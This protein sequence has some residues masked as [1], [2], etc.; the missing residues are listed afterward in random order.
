MD[1]RWL[2]APDGEVAAAM[3]RVRKDSRPGWVPSRRLVIVHVN[4]CLMIWYLGIAWVSLGV[5]IDTVQDNRIEPRDVRDIVIVSLVF[6]VWVVGTLFLYRWAQRPPS[7]KA[8]LR[9]WRQTLTALANGFDSRAQRR[10]SFSSLLTTGA[11]AIELSPRFAADRVEFGVLAR[12]RNGPREWRYVAVTLST[13]L[14]HVVLDSAQTRGVAALPVRMDREQRLPLAGD[15]DRSF[16]LFV[17]AGYE[18]DALFL[19]T[20]DVLAA[21]IDHAASWS[22]EMVDDTIVFF[23]PGGADFADGA[24][25]DAVSGVLHG[26]VPALAAR[27]AR[28]RD[29][30][31]KGQVFSPAVAAIEAMIE[32]PSRVWEEPTPKIGDDGRRLDLRDRR[33]GLRARLGL[34]GW[35][36]TL[37]FLYVVPG[38]FAFAGV[39][40]IVDGR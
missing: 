36:A 32:N 8:R 13:P 12:R 34:V 37:A 7:P 25:W 39:M 3:R 28:Y 26:A 31:V 21:L 9:E 24:A 33:S 35:I 19:L 38:L 15:V 10:S 18:K 14:P 17:P 27:A 30:R 22:I 5:R 29:E 2:T 11:E 20:P 40:S 23:A 16:R 1:L 6:V 4:H